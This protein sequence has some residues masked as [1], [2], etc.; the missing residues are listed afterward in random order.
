MIELGR[1]Q[2]VALFLTLTIL[3][4]VTLI[5]VSSVQTTSLQERMA[6]N[7]RG[8][9]IAFQGAEAAVK[10]AEDL[11]EA[12]ANI[13]AFPAED[14]DFTGTMDPL[15]QD[16]LCN[17]EDGTARWRLV[18]W[19][20]SSSDYV[21]ANTTAAQLGAADEPRYLVEFVAKVTIEQDTLNIGNVGEGGSS[22]RAY[23]YRI[24]ARGTGGTDQSHTMIQTLYGRQF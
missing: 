6:R 2:G 12:A 10:E 13:D 21:S 20:D 15:C 16:G 5:G 11:I 8:Q 1:Q 18:D 9:N 17:S 14:D 24:T 4:L 7:Y 22:G 23:I 19:S 3:L